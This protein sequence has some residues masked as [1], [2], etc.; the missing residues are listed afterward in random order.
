MYNTIRTIYFS[1]VYCITA[2]SLTEYGYYQHRQDY[3]KESTV[4]DKNLNHNI[5]WAVKQKNMDILEQMLN[6]VS[7]PFSQ[8]YGKYLNST[9]IASMTFDQEANSIVTKY[10]IKRNIR[11]ISQTLHGEYFTTEAP[12]STWENVFSTEFH[13]YKHINNEHPPIYRALNYTVPEELS[14]YLTSVLQIVQL[15]PMHRKPLPSITPLDTSTK[16]A[17][18]LLT[19][20]VL[21]SYYN[22]FTNT[23]SKAATQIIYSSVNQYFS[24]IDLSSFQ[25][26]YN[27]PSQPVDADL[28]NRNTFLSKIIISIGIK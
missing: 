15:P 28:Q 12:L 5:I 26:T 25:S 10:F 3:V 13:M 14:N 9:E 21:N 1:V 6:D 24:S 2:T 27:L 18:N 16:A 8:N 22:I 4:L 17:S 20:N 11:I 7:N 19:P 23:A